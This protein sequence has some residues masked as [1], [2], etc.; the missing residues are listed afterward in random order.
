VLRWF[1]F[2]EPGTFVFN[3]NAHEPG[4]Q[5]LLGKTYA[6]EGTRQGEAALL[7]DLCGRLTADGITAKAA[8]ADTPGCAWAIARYSDASLISQTWVT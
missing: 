2:G 6:P 1:H 7:K 4:P 3:P 8:L 5:I